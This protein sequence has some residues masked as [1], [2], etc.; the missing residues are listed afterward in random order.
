MNIED[1]KPEICTLNIILP[2][3]VSS[4]HNLNKKLTLVISLS[5]STYRFQ[6]PFLK[7][8]LV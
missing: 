1:S 2:N 5:R 7:K 3:F 6:E 4:T 8:K